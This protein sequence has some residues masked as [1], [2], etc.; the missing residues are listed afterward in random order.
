MSTPKTT[1]STASPTSNKGRNLSSTFLSFVQNLDEV[2]VRIETV[3]EGREYVSRRIK[4]SR[5]GTRAKVEQHGEKQRLS[6]H[7][8]MG[9][10]AELFHVYKGLLAEAR[11]PRP[12]DQE[13]KEALVKLIGNVENAALPPEDPVPIS[14]IK[15]LIRANEKEAAIAALDTLPEQLESEYDIARI[16][17]VVRQIMGLAIQ[18]FSTKT[19]KSHFP[20]FTNTAK[21]YG[22]QKQ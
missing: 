22:Q 11:C 12:Q 8:I 2:I 9:E 15:R 14:N 13:Y 4:T 6:P 19:A 5:K 18:Y 20:H 10:V 17:V 7:V 21:R 1:T 16:D 3:V